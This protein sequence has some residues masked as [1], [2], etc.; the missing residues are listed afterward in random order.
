M[1]DRSD[2]IEGPGAGCGAVHAAV[3]SAREVGRRAAP[4]A[5]AHDEDASFVTEGFAAIRDTGY[6]LLGVPRE[7]GGHGH[8]L[9]GVC[10][11]Q[12]ALARYCAS[13]SL[14]IATHHHAVLTL[15]WRWR[16]RQDPEAARLLRRIAIE[17]LILTVSL[18]FAPGVV[19]VDAVPV[20]GGYLASGVRRLAGG[21]PGADVFFIPVNLV[22]DGGTRQLQMLLPLRAAGTSLM[23]DWDSMGMRGSGCH[24]VRFTDTFVPAENAIHAD[25]AGLRL[26]DAKK[27][28]QLPGLHIAAVVLAASYLGSATAAGDAALARIG[29][30]R[31]MDLPS[32]RYLAGRLADE[33]Q[34]G[35]WTL[36][37]MIRRVK[38]HTLGT[39]D[40]VIPSLLGKRQVLLASLRAAELAMEML[41]SSSHRR[42]SFE[43]A[44]R[45]VRVGLSHQLNPEETLMEIG[46]TAISRSSA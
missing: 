7:F 25:L 20:E 3:E 34:C 1:T 23:D 15:A 22:A 4:F 24:T 39:T 45:D 13:T 5:A 21:S 44:V 32:V 27:V 41:G 42:G 30:R 11:A 40:L 14:A 19:G 10:K 18:D 9:E 17:R 35:W 16:H 36:D 2:P 26:I 29:S 28:F 6:A 33:I 31:D 38:D 12:A 8:D 43:R 37:G 46:R